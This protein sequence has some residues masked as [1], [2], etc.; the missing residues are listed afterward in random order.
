MALGML[1]FINFHREVFGIQE[2]MNRY[3]CNPD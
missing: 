1:E 3:S 2:I